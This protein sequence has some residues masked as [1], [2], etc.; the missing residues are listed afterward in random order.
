MT[1]TCIGFVPIEL[2]WC[3]RLVHTDV[4]PA[5]LPV[6]TERRVVEKACVTSSGRKK[7]D[8]REVHREAG[9]HQVD[10]VVGQVLL[11]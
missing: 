7:R 6:R 9:Q 11:T 5:E 2:R 4:G 8:G 3:E 10:L 1:A